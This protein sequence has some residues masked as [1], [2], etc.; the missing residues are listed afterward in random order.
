MSVYVVLK[1]SFI[2][3][4]YRF[5]SVIFINNKIIYEIVYEKEKKYFKKLSE[6]I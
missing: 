1:L 3:L 4:S 5:N 2:K 6:E